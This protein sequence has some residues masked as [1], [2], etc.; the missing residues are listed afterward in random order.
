MHR[1]TSIS[2]QTL[3]SAIRKLERGGIIFLAQS[4]SRT[5]TVYLTESGAEFVDRT[6]ARL[7]SAELSAFN[8]WAEDEIAQYLYLMEKF[9]NDFRAQI[10][11]M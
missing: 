7:F 9:N 8:G 10:E 2:K 6:V 5:K 3:N 1:E 4:G 11:K